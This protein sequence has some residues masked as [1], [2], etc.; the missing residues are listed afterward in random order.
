MSRTGQIVRPL[1]TLIALLGLGS[2]TL[3]EAPNSSTAD[4]QPRK[5]N[6]P[7]IA[8][9]PQVAPPTRAEALARIAE[10]GGRTYPKKPTSKD[11]IQHVYLQGTKVADADL[12]LLTA[13][14][15]LTLIEL[16]DTKITDT[17]LKHLTGM[18]ELRV[19]RLNN[20]SVT[21]K[22]L[23]LLAPL[24]KLS[25]I[26]LTGITQRESDIARLKG[27]KSLRGLSAF[28]NKVFNAWFISEELQSTGWVA[29]KDKALS[30]RL[31]APK[32]SY[33]TKETIVL[34]AE[35]RNNSKQ[36]LLVL[37]PFG[38]S[39]RA[40]RFSL[41]I[42]G[43][44][45]RCDYVGPQVLYILGPGALSVL[46]P[47]RIIRDRLELSYALPVQLDESGRIVFPL[48]EREDPYTGFRRFNIKGEYTFSF[49]YSTNTHAERPA[50]RHF[51]KRKLW[52]G[53]IRSK[54]LKITKS[55]KKSTADSQPS[56]NRPRQRSG[57]PIK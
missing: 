9:T 1:V 14:P 40:I 51:P 16:S 49:L 4:S 20:T 10:L 45:G 23:L 12:R 53:T 48:T 11:P 50:A 54:E 13:L 21:V 33:D 39:P 28:P 5:A 35:L 2:A 8:P 52:T 38:D 46:G 7:Q 44:K 43:P 47:G 37:R 27:L 22:G 41:T 25:S 18:K 31:L 17:G 30:L 57:G 6:S 55:P 26:G 15:E 3:A 24:P 36:E 56:S 32:R 19:L 29:S 42:V 34:L